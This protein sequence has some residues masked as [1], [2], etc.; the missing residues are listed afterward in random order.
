M[1]H[2]E[3]SERQ[4]QVLRLVADGFSNQQIADH[5]EIALETVKSHVKHVLDTFGANSRAQAVAIGIRRGEI[6]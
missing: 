3:L 4:R 1:T 6:E 5:L 2:T